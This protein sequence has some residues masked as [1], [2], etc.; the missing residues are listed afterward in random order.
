[1]KLYIAKKFTQESTVRI[2]VRVLAALVNL[3][4]REQ[5]KSSFIVSLYE[6]LIKKITVLIYML[7]FFCVFNYKIFNKWFDFC[8]G[9]EQN[10]VTKNS[11]IYYAIMHTKGLLNEVT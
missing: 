8:L 6:F 11:I 4:Q 5:L 3:K 9:F 2:G 7:L 1:M 10:L